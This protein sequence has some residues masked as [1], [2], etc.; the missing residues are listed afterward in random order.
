LA[1][2]QLEPQPQEPEEEH[3]QSPMMMDLFGWLVGKVDSFVFVWIGV[4]W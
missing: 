1:Q 3:P 2:V 4:R